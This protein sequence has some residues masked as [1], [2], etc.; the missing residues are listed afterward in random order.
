MGCAFLAWTFPLCVLKDWVLLDFALDTWALLN[1]KVWVSFTLEE[2]GVEW[3]ADLMK[4]IWDDDEM[5]V[6]FLKPIP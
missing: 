2:E 6:L 4:L 3:D 5:D 1:W